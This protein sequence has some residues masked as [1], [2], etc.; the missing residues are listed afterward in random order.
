[1]QWA[2]ELDAMAVLGGAALLA[3]RWLSGRARAAVFALAAVACLT[4]QSALLTATVALFQMGILTAL[5]AWQPYAMAVISILALTI[6]QSAYQAG[7]LAASMP[8]M[9]TGNPVAAIVGTGVFKETIATG[10]ALDVGAGRAGKAAPTGV[11]GQL[12]E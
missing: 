1:V 10:R 12:G 2:Q 3:S 6:V 9:N 8:V 4:A 11:G 5:T 7:P